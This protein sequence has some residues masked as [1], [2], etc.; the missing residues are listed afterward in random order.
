M[1]VGKAIDAAL[2]EYGHELRRGRRP[3]LTAMVG[4]A[5]SLLDDALAEGAVALPVPDRARTMVQVEAVL[6]AYR[7]SELAGLA[8][9]RTRVMLIGQTVGVYAQPDYWDGRG[10][11]FE[12]KTFRAVPPPP[13][14]ALQVRLFQL[15][16][17]KFESVLF[18]IDRH[19]VPVQVLSATIPPP[20]P[21]ETAAALRLAYDTGL[22]LGQEK[23]LE[24][25]EGP[26]VYYEIPEPEG[27]AAAGPEQGRR[28][29]DPDG[30]A[31]P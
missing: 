30:P 3:T 4:W 5:G 8:R 22:E 21:R 18:C 28:T 10:R 2:T 17:P 20:T 7:G 29:E 19:A 9:P 31:R 23:V 27:A 13:D 26:F 24:Y 15:A 6:R 12:F 25:V 11:F 1:A 16:F 14:V